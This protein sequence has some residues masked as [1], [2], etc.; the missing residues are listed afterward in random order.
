M[1]WVIPLVAALALAGCAAGP[2]YV[3]PQLAEV[4]AWQASLPWQQ[5]EP[6]DAQPKGE[7]WTVFG[8]TELNALQRQALDANQNL[9]LAAARLAQA[10]AGVRAAEAG[11]WPTLD[12]NARGVRQKTSA[13]RPGSS[14][15]SQ[16]TSTVQND[17]SLLAAVGYE[18]D[19]FG[20]VAR[21]IE[22]AN[23]NRGQAEAD[24]ENVRLLVT[25]EVA[26]SWFSLRALDAELDVL[27][28]GLAFQQRAVDVL[29]ARY[30]E[31]TASG[32]ELAQQQAQREATLT[33]FDLAERQRK[34]LEHALATL[35]G[36]PAPLFQPPPRPLSLDGPVAVPTLPLGVPATLLQ[37]R[38]DIAAAER[39]VAAANALIGVASAARFPSLRLSA[40]GGWDSSELSSL[41]SAPSVLWSLGAGLAYSVVDGGRNAA[42]VDAAQAQHQGASALYRLT[43]LRAMQEVEDSAASL[44]AY[45]QARQHAGAA[46][47]SAERT[48]AIAT[49]RYRGGVASYLE[50]VTASQA[51]L[52]N[53]RQLA[54]LHGQQLVSTV[55]LIRAL[56]GGWQPAAENA[57]N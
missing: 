55:Q 28:Q 26:G 12:L 35:I 46:T 30:E 40:I 17:F 25:A 56:G 14:Y 5:G 49:D 36:T 4:P 50:V 27:R 39:Q 42:R 54:Q 11:R 47:V 44:V 20:R 10:R 48:L 52:N 23:A 43:V 37:R 53:R 16:S 1:R 41:V 21:E 7:W 29:Q 34:L 32:L 19:L 13:N 24:A 33:Q 15:D 9:Q 38:P 51:V 57:A 2:D 18:V 45:D 6:A 3:R 22:A 8:D 31:G